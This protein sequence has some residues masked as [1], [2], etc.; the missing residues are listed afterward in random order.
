MKRPFNVSRCLSVSFDVWVPHGYSRLLTD[1]ARLATVLRSY[2][3]AREYDG[4]RFFGKR[5]S[6]LLEIVCGS[7]SC[8]RGSSREVPLA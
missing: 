2:A 3:T 1:D 6:Q 8:S 7:Y 5:F 4:G